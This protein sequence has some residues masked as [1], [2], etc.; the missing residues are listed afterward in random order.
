MNE[1]LH[2]DSMTLESSCIDNLLA[3]FRDLL[4]TRDVCNLLNVSKPTVY[5]LVDSQELVAIDICGRFYYPK[6]AVKTL[7]QHKIRRA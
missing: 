4:T 3:P 1:P 7:L 6:A 5:G 2:T